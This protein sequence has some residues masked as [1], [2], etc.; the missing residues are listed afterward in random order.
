MIRIPIESRVVRGF[1]PTRGRR[2]K[3]V[4]RERK[5]SHPQGRES[6]VIGAVLPKKR[7][8]VLMGAALSKKMDVQAVHF[9]LCGNWTEYV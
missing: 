3:D 2:N 1:K 6:V 9:R 4:F 7:T 8:S 5:G